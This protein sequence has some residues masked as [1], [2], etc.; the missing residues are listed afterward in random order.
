MNEITFTEQEERFISSILGTNVIYTTLAGPDFYLDMIERVLRNRLNNPTYAFSTQAD[1]LMNSIL[2]KIYDYR[3]SKEIEH[4]LEV[5]PPK[6]PKPTT[7]SKSL[8]SLGNTTALQEKIL[9]CLDEEPLT[10]SEIATKTNLRMSS[11]CGRVNEL[12]NKDQV[13]VVGEKQDEDSG[14]W[15]ELVGKV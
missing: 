5:N 11:V 10:R 2:Y 14:R 4:L 7:K 12:I 13:Q 9:T 1:I 15:V 8:K 3:A 6:K